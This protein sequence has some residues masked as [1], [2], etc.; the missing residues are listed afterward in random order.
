[1]IIRRGVAVT[2]LTTDGPAGIPRVTGVLTGDGSAI[3]ADLVVDCGGRRSAL[4]SWL[5]AA[6]ARR[7]A[8]ERADCGFVYYARHFRSPGGER[9]ALLSNLLQSYDSLS[10]I[11]LPPTTAPGAW[12]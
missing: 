3:S 4:G 6:G 1:V 5:Q 11:T 2:G 7:P 8:E 12:S 10:V 9:P